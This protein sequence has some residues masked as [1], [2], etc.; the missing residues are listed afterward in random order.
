[1]VALAGREGT[2]ESDRTPQAGS[3]W[4]KIIE[5]QV[6]AIPEY[7]TFIVHKVQ[8]GKVKWFRVC[9]QAPMREAEE[10]VIRMPE[11]DP[12]VFAELLHFIYFD[13]LS[14]DLCKLFDDRKIAENPNGKIIYLEKAT[15]VFKLYS[16][17]KKLGMEKLQNIALD[18]VID[19]NNLCAPSN[20][21]LNYMAANSDDEDA[22]YRYIFQYLAV[23]A[24]TYSSDWLEGLLIYRNG[25]AKSHELQSE[26]TR[27]M[28]KHKNGTLPAEY[29]FMARCNAWH[30]HIETEKCA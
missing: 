13:K 24:F 1:M 4:N 21:M 17:A 7:D 30:T 6:G 12:A 15:N 18:A 23:G 8:L 14:C 10:G 27:A 3:D 25:I 28:I 20:N 2:N 26:L 19:Y 9:L 29:S 5:I 11:D 16:L 22:L